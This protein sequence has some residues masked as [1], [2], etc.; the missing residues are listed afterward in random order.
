M[1]KQERDRI[2]KIL[3]SIRNEKGDKIDAYVD[4]GLSRATIHRIETGDGNVGGSAEG[5]ID[6]VRILAQKM[7]KTMEDIMERKDTSQLLFRMYVVEQLIEGRRVEEA[8]TALH[9]MKV[10]PQTGLKAYY[11]YLFAKGYY[12]L[13][14]FDHALR[15]GQQVISECRSGYCPAFYNMESLVRSMMAKIHI[16]H[17][18]YRE[19]LDEIEEAL[20]CFLQDGERASILASLKADKAYVLTRLGEYERA[21]RIIDTLFQ[22]MQEIVIPD[23]KFAVYELA[24]RSALRKQFYQRASE[25][26][27][28]G[29]NLILYHKQKRP[30]LTL[31]RVLL[32]TY[33]DTP[34]EDLQMAKILCETLLVFV[35][36]LEDGSDK[37]QLKAEFQSVLARVWYKQD[38]IEEARVLYESSVALHTEQVEAWIGLGDCYRRLLHPDDA[39][40][41]YQQ[42][43]SLSQS[44]YPDRLKEIY[45]GLAHCYS[46]QGDSM[47]ELMWLRK[48]G[49]LTDG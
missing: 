38:Q 27:Q 6:K 1:D 47:Q 30:Y 43:L 44:R 34:V 23:V 49:G 17:G 36:D 42:G 26:G 45:V 14:Q 24:A 10:S 19:A 16:E 13:R 5:Y 18:K 12:Y 2:G 41:A 20:D 21:D 46:A 39:I 7:G 8:F 40:E 4:E 31:G 28:V 3:R 48:A 22:K 32:E 25:I 33:M 37:N 15:I 29:V 35:E 11:H 9:E